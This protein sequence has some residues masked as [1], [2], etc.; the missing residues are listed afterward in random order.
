M[1]KR[2]DD[3]SLPGE[4]TGAPQEEPRD[5][6]LAVL[7][8]LLDALHPGLGR[9]TP[10]VLEGSQWMIWY[11]GGCMKSSDPWTELIK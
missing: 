4:V 5:A 7:H 9:G 1:P 8:V 10:G 2:L 3:L 11:F 6:V